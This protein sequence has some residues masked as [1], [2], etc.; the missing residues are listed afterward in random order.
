ML[1]LKY[2]VNGYLIRIFDGIGNR[3]SLHSILLL[4]DGLLQVATYEVEDPCNR[5]TQN[6]KYDMFKTLN[7]IDTN[8]NIFLVWR[9]SMSVC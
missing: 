5:S 7:M 9:T 2:I 3:K 1:I 4:M 8:A 6:I